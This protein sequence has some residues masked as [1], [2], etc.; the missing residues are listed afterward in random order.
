MLTALPKKSWFKGIALFLAIEIVN[1]FAFPTISFALTSGPSQPEVQSFEPVTTTNMVNQFT[2]DFT[3]NLP[4]FTIPGPGGGYP[5]NI[6]YHAGISMDQEASWVGLG[7]TLNPGVINRNVRGIPDDF[8]GDEITKEIDIKPSITF[9]VGVNFSGHPETIGADPFKPESTTSLGATFYYNNNK[10]LGYSLNVGHSH[11][12]NESKTVGIG[13]N[14]SLDNQQ[15]VSANAGLSLISLNDNDQTQ[16]NGG[17]GFNSKTGLSYSSSISFTYKKGIL[18]AAK[19]ANE[20][21]TE[22]CIANEIWLS[23]VINNR[24]IAI[25]RSLLN[26]S[27][28]KDKIYDEKNAALNTLKNDKS[29]GSAIGGGTSFASFSGSFNPNT[30]LE[31]SNYHLSISLKKGIGTNGF[32]KNIAVDGFY[33]HQKIKKSNQQTKSFGFEYAENNSKPE[34]YQRGIQD[35]SREKDG[36]VVS[37]SSNVGIPFKTTDAYI[38]NTQVANIMFKPFRNEVGTVFDPYVLSRGIGGSASYNTGTGKV[39]IG[40]TLSTN[41]HYSG[42][43]DPYLGYNPEPNDWFA[44]FQYVSSEQSANTKFAKISYHAIGENS[45][46]HLNEFD[47]M[48]GLQAVRANLEKANG[49]S[50]NYTPKLG[51]VSDRNNNT[52]SNA[53]VT[54]G[55]RN[56]NERLTTNASIQSLKNKEIINADG[57][58]LPICKAYFYNSINPDYSSDP[59]ELIRTNLPQ[60]HNGAFIQHGSAGTTSIFALPVYNNEENQVLFSTLHDDINDPIINIEEDEDKVKYKYPG[61]DKFYTKTKMPKY[62]YCYLLTSIIGESYVDVDNNGPSDGDLGYWVK[63]NYTKYANNY[64]WRAP[65]KGANFVPGLSSTNRDNKGAYTYGDKEVYYLATVET[66]THIAIFR[67]TERNDNFE[68]I[69][70][71]VPKN[72]A[73]NN[74]IGGKSG[75]K[76]D[77]IDLYQKSEYKAL[78]ESALPL[79]SVHFQYTYDLCPN[80]LNNNAAVATDGIGNIN[81]YKGKLSL[82][83]IWFTYANNTKGKLAPYEFFYQQ[84]TGSGYDYYTNPGYENNPSYSENRYDRWGGFRSVNGFSESDYYLYPYVQQMGAGFNPDQSHNSQ[85][86]L[87]DDINKY[88]ASW[89][90]DKIKLPGKGEINITYESDDYAYVQNEVATQMFKIANVYQSNYSGT[91]TIDIYDDNYDATIPNHNRIEFYLE[92]PI[93]TSTANINQ[94]IY[95]TYLKELIKDESLKQY[96]YFKINAELRDGIFEDV[97]GY[98]EIDQNAGICGPVANST[99]SV[100]IDGSGPEPCYTRAYFLFKPEKFWKNNQ[101]FSY[102]PLAMAAWQHMRTND[103]EMLLATGNLGNGIE[104]DHSKAQKAVRPNQLISWI[105]SLIQ[106]FSG[107]RDYARSHNYAKRINPAKSFIRLCSPDKVKFGGGHRVKTIA[108]NDNWNN[109]V[110]SET[111]STYGQ[112]FDYTCIDENGNKIT[113]GVATYEPNAGGDEIALRYPK[114]YPEV[115]KFSSDN[116]LFFENPINE[117]QFPS[118]SVGYSKVKTTSLTT[119]KIFD[120]EIPSQ[121]RGTGYIIQE[122]YTAKDFP[123]VYEQTEIV[124]KPFNLLIPMPFIGEVSIND[125]TVSQG[126]MIELNDMHGKPKSIENYGYSV[127]EQNQFNP[128]LTSAIQYVYKCKP[129]YARGKDFWVLENEVDVLLSN[130][131]ENSPTYNAK[132]EKRLL[133]VNADY[134]VDQRQS[135]GRDL[136]VGFDYDGDLVGTV[137]VFGAWPTYKHHTRNLKIIATNKIVSRNGI[138]EKV[139]YFNGQ[140]KTTTFNKLFDQYT[141]DVLLTI[142]KNDFSSDVFQYSIPAYLE[143]PQM[144]PSFFSTGTEF[145][146]LI[147]NVSTSPIGADLFEITALSNDLKST[148]IKGDEYLIR[149]K[150]QNGINVTQELHTGNFL[151][152]NNNNPVF[153]FEDANNLTNALD[154][155][156]FKCIKSGNSNGQS[157]LASSILA[158]SDPT[159]NRTQTICN[160]ER[161]DFPLDAPSNLGNVKYYAIDNVINASVATFSD[162]WITDF[163]DSRSSVKDWTSFNSNNPYKYHEKGIWRSWISYAYVDQRTQTTSSG[164]VNPNLKVDGVI[165]DFQFFNFQY[166]YKNDC[167]SDKW[168]KVEEIISYSPYGDANESRD[169]LDIYSSALFGNAGY[170]ATMVTANGQRS[171]TG[172]ENFEDLPSF[173][174]INRNKLSAG[175]LDFYNDYANGISNPTYNRI[176]YRDVLYGICSGSTNL[177]LIKGSSASYGSVNF[178]LFAKTFNTS[179]SGVSE[180]IMVLNVNGTSSA[181]GGNTLISLTSTPFELSDKTF[182]GKIGLLNPVIAPNNPTNTSQITNLKAHT[183]IKSL[184]LNANTI[185]EQGR[186]NLIPGKKYL[187]SFWYSN[188]N[189]NVP[190]YAFNNTFDVVLRNYNGTTFTTIPKSSNIFKNRIIEGWQLVEFEFTC[191]SNM[192]KLAFEIIPGTLNSLSGDVFIDDFK[193]APF[194]SGSSTFVYEMAKYR[195][196]ATLDDNHFATI[197]KYDNDGSLK[198]TIQ[199][200]SKG[201]FT[202]TEN[203]GN[204]AH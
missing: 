1:S 96:V 197:Y 146:V 119:Q 58:S 49:I 39:G 179:G 106:V 123:V 2:G 200:T 27:I 53:A 191:P 181:Y 98:L 3:Y 150:F 28:E 175:N 186:L 124:A 23:S 90:L 100:D 159:K 144:G 195:L 71:I 89:S 48:G 128:I 74:S 66:A 10:G 189:T 5:F 111:N 148:L 67:T 122:F 6:A 60:D 46:R 91:G 196:V 188:S 12:I 149:F 31:T 104:N 157:N 11:A 72:T 26:N 117:T 169:I 151:Y 20:A 201:Q 79:Q 192:G 64:K 57:T 41:Y 55:K 155:I 37:T 82:K 166:P 182:I 78:G 167:L 194:E 145:P 170:L 4:L 153:I 43:W 136:T 165:N 63:F 113:S 81:T 147:S 92:N 174:T 44:N 141:G 105:P 129:S 99:A 178:K 162:T 127:N 65:F 61:T 52:I 85:Q 102:S 161:K 83:K 16:F 135:S 126:Y 101:E 14:L 204:N 140:S 180:N 125:L 45:P 108:V 183:G 142:T 131:D 29:I 112:I 56:V 93:P 69:G 103:P 163:S 158:L 54:S 116:N 75:L 62:A 110:E 70:E 24:P 114:Y 15:G 202:V 168:K 160:I 176:A 95:D 18:K 76:L 198:L 109:M 185:F 38:L 86:T 187:I 7:W 94:V 19:E 40:A 107:Y 88:A 36:M 80:V 138:L 164:T 137:L 73:L 203:R 184:K 35:F 25:R 133:G 177:L 8:N 77:R 190:S 152:F 84:N 21:Y 87:K 118:P 17:I 33:N 13:F 132:T 22:K 121:T 130:V 173:S 115:V 171:E 134:C 199:E 139:E 30:G 156:Y 143:Y 193:I 97:S 68:S 34:N 50:N 51:E 47:Y 9:G 120:G 32:F 172:F 42:P 59:S 154:T